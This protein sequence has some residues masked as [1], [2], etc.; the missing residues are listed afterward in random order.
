MKEHVSWVNM[1]SWSFERAK[2]LLCSTKAYE[3]MTSSLENLEK[4]SSPL[5]WCDVN[6]VAEYSSWNE[7]ERQELATARIGYPSNNYNIVKI[8]K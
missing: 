6:I 8:F 4:L 2:K 5:W 1:E 3:S 7:E